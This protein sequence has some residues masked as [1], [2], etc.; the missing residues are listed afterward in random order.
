MDLTLSRTIGLLVVAIFV[1]IVSRRLRLPYTVGLVVTGLSLALAP[2]VANINLTYD[3]IFDVIL[4]PLLF[5]AALSIHWAE[6]RRDALPVL[7]LATIGVAISAVVVALGM[8]YALGWALPSA[9]IFGVLIAATDPVAVIAMFKDTGIKGRLRLLVESESLLNDGVAAVLF[10]IALGWAQAIG[11]GATDA[12][13]IARSLALT[14]GGGVLIGLACG[15]VAIAAAGR[16]QDR[17]IETALTTVAAYGSFQLA[18]RF[19]LSGVLAT[20]AAGLLMGN[21][22]ILGR[23]DF[24]L[25]SG[26]EFVIAFWEFA[27]FIANSFVFLLIGLTVG[28]LPLTGLGPVA[29]VAAIGFVLLGRALTVYPL[30][31]LFM[32][33]ALGDSTARPARVVVGRIAWRARTGIGAR[34][35]RY[36]ARPAR[37]RHR[38]IQCRCVL[39]HRAGPDH[40]SGASF[41]RVLPKADL[42]CSA[43]RGAAESQTRERARLRACVTGQRRASSAIRDVRA[44]RQEHCPWPTPDLSVSRCFPS[45]EPRGPCWRVRARSRRCYTGLMP[46]LT[47]NP[48]V[49]AGSS[50]RCFPGAQARS[51]GAPTAAPIRVSGSRSSFRLPPNRPSARRMLLGLRARP[52]QGYGTAEQPSRS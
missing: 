39:R 40:A 5:E 45:N 51:R 48:W 30:C 9:V 32:R 27:A 26:R 36:A 20:V 21:L 15:G 34:A 7:T 4:P 1:A 52:A 35:A 22:G 41:A 19:H 25:L 11:Q 42:G 33:L 31:L 28:H 23:R 12:G 49:P 47:S 18:E 6:L 38:G 16:T 29:V 10:V 2:P 44:I 24:F 8:T 37:N 3:F 13:Q 43:I 50:R 46:H 17:L 14:S